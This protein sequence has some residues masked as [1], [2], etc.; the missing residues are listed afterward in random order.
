M[1]FRRMLGF[2]FSY[3]T[4]ECQLPVKYVMCLLGH[5]WV[6][7][8]LQYRPI[9]EEAIRISHYFEQLARQTIIAKHLDEW[10]ATGSRWILSL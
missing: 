9:V 5:Q 10:T 3:K 1:K 8:R 6:C 2:T 7:L 4:G